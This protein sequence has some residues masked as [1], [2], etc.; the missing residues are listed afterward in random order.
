MKVDDTF[1][2]NPVH[3][4]EACKIIAI[5]AFGE[6]PYFSQISPFFIELLISERPLFVC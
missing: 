2:N 1:G 4:K 6:R 5:L 3:N